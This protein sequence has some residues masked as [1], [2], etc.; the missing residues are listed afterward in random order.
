[1]INI[2]DLTFSYTNKPPYLIE[3]VNLNIPKGI[4]LSIIGENGSAKT[5]LV[6]LILGLLKPT[7]GTITVNAKGIA[8]VPQKV[9]S[10]NSQFPIS[11]YEILKTHGNSIGIKN[12]SE[13]EKALDKVNMLEF[14]NKLIGSLSGGQQQRVFIG[15]ALMGNPE[16]IILDEPSTGVDFKNQV[17][18][19]SLLSKLN[20]ENGKTIISVEH[21]VNMALKYSTHILEVIEGNPTLY[22]ID[23]YLKHKDSLNKKILNL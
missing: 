22:T 17:S 16:L 18:I 4:Y 7:S 10:F 8:Y 3:N 14:T 19:Y 13:I 20:K 6:K 1:M 5:T 23:E 9:E 2:K 12:K 15:R 11:V 21:N